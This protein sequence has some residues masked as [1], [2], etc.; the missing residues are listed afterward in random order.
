M[1]CFK[2][3]PLLNFINFKNLKNI[4]NFT[5]CIS[6]F[7]LTSGMC[8]VVFCAAPLKQFYPD[9]YYPEDKIYENKP[10]HFVF[11]FQGNWVLFT[12]PNEM[13]KGSKELA[14]TMAKS[15]AEL[16]FVGATVEGMHGARGIAVNFNEPPHEYAERIRAINR[17]EVQ[18][19]QG[20]TDMVLG[21]NAMVKWVYDKADFR[22]AEFFF[23]IDTYDIRISF[24]SHSS[25]FDKFLPVY[26]Q[27]MSSLEVT[28]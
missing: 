22:F 1:N 2:F 15:G 27:M 20:L 11:K 18:D 16:L 4:M 23:T 17:N 7:L 19:D 12:D 8:L 3:F 21:N 26:E 10:L 9:T 14:A 28:R 13:D 6:R 5:N 25:L 24:W